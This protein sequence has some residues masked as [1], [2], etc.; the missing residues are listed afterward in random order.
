MTF[1]K[2]MAGAALAFALIAGAG[3]ASAHEGNAKDEVNPAA[4]QEKDGKEV[5]TVYDKEGKLV[6]DKRFALVRKEFGPDKP[7]KRHNH[8]GSDV[9]VTLIKG[10]M[11]VT[12]NDKEKHALEPSMILHFDGKN[13]IESEFP[14]KSLIQ[15]TLI[16]Q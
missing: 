10:K 12:I 7:M 14:E 4:A 3:V 1:A 6:E 15:V 8:P 13:Y 5:A 9:Y 11:N 16:N 2:G